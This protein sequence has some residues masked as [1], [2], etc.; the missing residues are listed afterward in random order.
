MSW[1]DMECHVFFG[2][3]L[4]IG[5]ICS[6]LSSGW[7]VTTAQS[8]RA[9]QGTYGNVRGSGGRSKVKGVEATCS[10]PEAADQPAD[11]YHSRKG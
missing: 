9:K 4:T 8:E 2:K 6:F 5:E 11:R 10:G 7:G 3:F 1:N